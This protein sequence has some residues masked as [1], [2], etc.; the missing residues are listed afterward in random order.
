[1][2]IYHYPETIAEILVTLIRKAPKNMLAMVQ[3]P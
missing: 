3:E 1:M 2:F